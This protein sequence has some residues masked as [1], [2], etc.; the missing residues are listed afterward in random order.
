MDINEDQE[1]NLDIMCVDEYDI[2]KS[3]DVE[4]DRHH[5]NQISKKPIKQTSKKLPEKI[6]EKLPE[7]IE[8]LEDL[9][10]LTPVGN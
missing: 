4:I 2:F 10:D 1:Q 3:M 9:E 8:D 6:P 5:R 7:I